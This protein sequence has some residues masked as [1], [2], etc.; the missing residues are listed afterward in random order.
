MLVPEARIVK[1]LFQSLALVLGVLSRSWSGAHVDE[2]VYAIAFSISIS[3]SAGRRWAVD[4][5][6]KR[7]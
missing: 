3:T 4:L 7:P 1:Q 6:H 2:P 5:F